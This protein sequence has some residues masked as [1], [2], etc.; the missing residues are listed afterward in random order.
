MSLICP[1]IVQTGLAILGPRTAIPRHREVVQAGLGHY[2][3]MKIVKV[4][5]RKK[6]G[7][8]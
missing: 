4:D 2:A 6:I 5:R 8:L 3:I 1:W 7:G